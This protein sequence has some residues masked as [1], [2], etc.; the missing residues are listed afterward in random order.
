MQIDGQIDLCLNGNANSKT[1]IDFCRNSSGILQFR[2]CYKN[3]STNVLA[4]DL[5][6]QNLSEIPKLDQYENVTLIDLRLNSQLKA[7][8]KTDFVGLKLLDDLY[9]PE[10]F[11][12]PGG[13]RVWQNIDRVNDTDGIRCQHQKDFCTN[14]TDMCVRS[15]SICV[16]NGPDHFLCLCKMDYYG[17]KCLRHGHFSMSKLLG[18][19]FLVTVVLSTF[20]YF[21]HRKNVK[22]D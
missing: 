6:E 15:T 22:K 10:Q 5:T 21:S 4:I 14:S 3:S 11:A 17:Y 13:K 20:F 7:S 12:C 9:L 1:V 19:T 18:L 16:T 8:I 2:C